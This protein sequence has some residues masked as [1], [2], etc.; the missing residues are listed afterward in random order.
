MKRM[1][2][3]VIS[4]LT[5]ILASP[6][7]Y[8]SEVSQVTEEISSVKSETA[9]LESEVTQDKINEKEVDKIEANENIQSQILR[10]GVKYAPENPTPEQVESADPTDI[11]IFDDSKIENNVANKLKVPIGEIT[12]ADMERLDSIGLFGYDNTIVHNM[13]LTGLEYAIHMT[14]I[15][16]YGA[17][18]T[19]IDDLTPISNLKQLKQLNLF[20]CGIKDV[21]TLSN[22]TNLNSL[23]LGDN[24]INDISSLSKLS[25]LENI[26]I[27]KNEISDITVLANFP[28]VRMLDISNTNV[29]D[30]SIL[31]NL[32][33]LQSL[34]LSNIK[35]NDIS[36]IQ[37]LTNLFVLGAENNNI[38][39]ISALRK[40]TKLETV[41]L[42]N[43][44][45]SDIT[46]MSKLVNIKDLDLS[47]NKVKETSALSSMI[48]MLYLYLD[49][50]E[51]H[52]ISAASNMP[53]LQVLWVNNNNITTIPSL[54]SSRQ[55]FYALS[56]NNNNISDLSTLTQF[57]SMGAVLALDLNNQ[58]I[59]LP[60]IVV[61]TNAEISHDIIGFE[62][63][64]I[65]IS[66]GVPILGENNLS[67]LYA[68]EE[69]TDNGTKI[70]YNVTIKQ[71]V[72]YHVISAKESVTI[73]EGTILTDE[74]ILELFNVENANG[75]KVSVDQSA[76]DYN[77]PATYNIILS[78]G[79]DEITVSLIVEDIL[80]TIS[81]GNDTLV[82]EVGS[83]E[84]NLVE[85]F[86]VIA[87]EI[88]EG[89]L[90]SNIKIN[91]SNVDYNTIGKYNV[92]FSVTDN[93]DNLVEKSATVSVVSNEKST[94]EKN[95]NI[96][97]KSQQRTNKEAMVTPNSDSQNNKLM[98]TGSNMKILLI[99]L[100][101]IFT[102]V[103]TW[104]K[105][106]MY[107]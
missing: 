59:E 98:S 55:F 76:V 61:N 29:T 24:E 35:T 27:S 80:P 42:A 66:L 43:N 49:N 77:V 10:S 51:I 40:L 102:V 21:T 65:P 30:T 63:E 46:P 74:K 9:K 93:E 41:Y 92:T 20:Q 25:K 71:K 44:N 37:N 8:A 14:S 32:T 101:L 87:T 57:K 3:L 73:N 89:D 23:G 60:D 95:P 106:R 62:G 26:S 67:A 91:D 64:K 7:L 19:V 33:K 79:T 5:I 72:T 84:L 36:S 54:Q 104:K 85:A 82:I 39:D 86:E 2:T 6:M 107:L 31:S 48:N 100:T 69:L 45:I 17:K 53:Q 97:N 78:D 88:I 56:A 12:V 13:D 50:N 52:E 70:K 34:G 96:S 68:V 1:F 83:N 16:I 99:I 94:L 11:V 58:I 105:K 38:S 103:I 15:D 4:V 18:K 75:Q 47:N 22:L 90:T 81:I 28:S